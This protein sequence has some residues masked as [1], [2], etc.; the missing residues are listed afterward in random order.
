[1]KEDAK[2]LFLFIA[3][4]GCWPQ[5][6]DMHKKRS[7]FLWE[8]WFKSGLIDKRGDLTDAGFKLAEEL[9]NP[10]Q[11]AAAEAHA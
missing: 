6:T 4:T 1:M 5:N 2:A 3:N 11:D 8:K 10:P 7:A 9:R